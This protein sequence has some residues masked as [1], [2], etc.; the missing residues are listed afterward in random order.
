VGIF[1]HD[2]G[3]QRD[4]LEMKLVRYAVNHNGQ[5]AGIAEDHFVQTLGGWISFVGRLHVSGQR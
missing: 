4:P 2:A 5:D 1:G 3:K